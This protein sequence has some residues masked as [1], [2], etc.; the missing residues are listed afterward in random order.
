[1]KNIAICGVLRREN[2]V[3]AKHWVDLEARATASACVRPSGEGK[4]YKL[5]DVVER[6]GETVHGYV[7]CADMLE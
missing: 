5:G 2:G 6:L 7:L 4:D 1:M 3:V